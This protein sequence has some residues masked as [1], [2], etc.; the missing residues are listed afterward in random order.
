MQI[1]WYVTAI[2]A[3]LIWGIHYPL[4]DHALKKLSLFSVLLL[5][6]APLLLVIPFF[7]QDISQDIKTF[8]GL[9][10]FDQLAILAIGLTSVAASVLLFM[11]IGN[12]NATLA[13]LIEITYPAFVV[14]F[15]WLI[16]RELHLNA[17]VIIGGLLIMTGAALIIFNNQQP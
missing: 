10:R 13:S 6:V 4:I 16:F 5:T 15:A 1:P 2:G 12:K 11:S 9:P 3:A 14:V 17:S 7:T 8:N